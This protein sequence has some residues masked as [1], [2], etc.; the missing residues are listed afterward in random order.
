[1]KKTAPVILILLLTLPLAAFAM[2]DDG[3]FTL[4]GGNTFSFSSGVGGWWTEII[5]SEDGS[6]TG[7]F[8]DSDMGDTGDGYPEGTLYECSFSGMFVEN[9]KIDEC[10]YELRLAALEYEKEPGEEGIAGGLKVINTDAYGI[11]G[12]DVFMLYCPG[13]ETADLPEEF[14]EWICM[15]NAWVEPPETLPF[16]GLYNVGEGTGFYAYAEAEG[17]ARHDYDALAGAWRTAEDDEVSIT[18]LLYPDDAFRLYQYQE[19]ENETFMLEGVRFVEGDVITVSDIRL[20]VLDA[21]GNYTQIGEKDT[22]CFK[23]SLGLGGAPSLAL[24]DQEGDTVILYP[25]DLDSPG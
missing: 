5:I 17:D 2:A 7:Y 12:G 9:G 8:H 15:P 20:G 14:L 19:D 23:F 21:E 25:V 22:V 1:M 3:V 11:E 10:T 6:F 24:T 18:L 16:Y 13:R 4:I